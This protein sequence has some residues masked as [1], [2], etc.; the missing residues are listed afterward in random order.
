MSVNSMGLSLLGE[1]FSKGSSV[2]T[3]AGVL[4]VL[5]EHQLNSMTK[6]KRVPEMKDPMTLV[7]LR[8]YQVGQS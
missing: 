2:K 5:R 7:Y 1:S 6:T 4:K 8:Q 3:D